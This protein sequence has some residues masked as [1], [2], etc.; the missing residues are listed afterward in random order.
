VKEIIYISDL[1]KPKEKREYVQHKKK[2]LVG[3][4]VVFLFLFAVFVIT[5]A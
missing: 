4:I 3:K 5:N 2:V 1:R